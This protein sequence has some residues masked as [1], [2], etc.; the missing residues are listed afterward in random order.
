MRRVV[1]PAD[2]VLVVMPEDAEI[3]EECPEEPPE[4]RC[5]GPSTHAEAGTLG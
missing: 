4:V 2:G 5:S 1:P 3:G